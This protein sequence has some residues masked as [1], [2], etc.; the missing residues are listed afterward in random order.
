MTWTTACPDWEQR[1]IEGRS[2]VPCEPLFPGEAERA[3][4]VFR[5]L[6]IVDVPGQPTFGEACGQ[7]VFDFVSA[8]FGSYDAETGQRLVREFLLAVS[9]KNSKALALDTPI[10][11][12]SGWTTMG[13]L[14]P[15]DEVFGVDGR[16]CR[17]LAT[18]E[19][20]TDHRC[21]QLEFSNGESVVADAGHLWLT[22]ALAD[23]PGVGRGNSEGS[24]DNRRK[25]V[26]TTQEIVDTL[27][28]PGDG[29]RNH[30]IL[31][32]SA[33]QCDPAVL[34][35]EP[36]TLGAW[37]GDGHSKCARITC[38]RDDTEILDGIRA[39]GWPIRF[40][41]NNGSAADTYSI[42]DGDRSQ[43]ARRV[44]LAARLR[45]AGVL[46]SKHIP[47]VYFRASF[48]QRLALLQGL[49]DTDGTVNKNGRV[50]SFSGINRRLVE[51]VQELLS[52]FGVKSSLT[53][54]DARLDGRTVGTVHVVQFMAFRDELPVFRLR[55][56]LDRMRASSGTA[57]RSRTVQIV[58]AREVPSVPVKCISVDAPDRQFLF[59]RTMLPT[60]NSTLAAAIMVTA[61]VLNWRQSGELLI[62]A[63]T[64]EAA[65]N[66]FKPAA[67]MVRADPELNA[68]MHI[69]DH[70]KTITHRG[71]KAT[72][73]VVAADTS[74]V[75]G[76]K[77]GFVLIDELWE[78]GTK[79]NAEAMLQEATG[80]LVSRPE[81][82]VIAITTQSDRPPAGVFKARLNYFRKVRD[83][84]IADP[85][86]LAV[87][88]EFPRR[89]I[90]DG[91]Y[92][93]PANFYITNPNIGR[94]VSREWIEDQLRKV[95][96]AGGDAYHT[97]LAKHL[98]V[99][100]GQ[101]IGA[102]SWAGAQFWQA[103]TEKDLD[104]DRLLA[105]SEVV[106][107]GIDGGGLDDLLSLSVLGRDAHNPRIWRHWGH[108][109][110]AEVVLERRKSEAS[111][112]RDFE[113]AGE[114]TI[115]DRPGRDIDE[116]VAVCERVDETG[117][118]AFVGLDPAGVGAIVDALA[119]K[120]IGGE[121]DPAKSR[122]VGVSQGY[123]LQGAVK[124]AERKLA[125]GTLTHC[126][127]AIMA[128]AVGNAKVEQKGNALMVTKQAAGSKIDPVMSLFDSVALMTKNPVAPGKQVSPWEDETY[129]LAVI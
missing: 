20:F 82:F 86:S 64:I 63:P 69:Q 39:E 6:R 2:L 37:L 115:V 19:V 93:D 97:F 42:T 51:G 96:E 48:D 89:M 83:G 128:W 23:R 90:D 33:I 53:T 87:I 57:S 127:Q 99:E 101:S 105:R 124:T 62:L 100:I 121:G 26:R 28:R 59:G 58:G 106:V 108:S 68:L 74:T 31:M 103:Q 91:A 36:Y 47:D 120:G 56:K 70:I 12:P 25:R 107:V 78:F 112:L 119:E 126:G 14:K 80:G 79:P 92:L 60:H 27:L 125:E 98:N 110:A 9:K 50:L 4:A 22:K 40:A 34:P 72:L 16:P 85:K 65:Q 75:V 44:C 94:S 43:S 41:H 52:T 66:S 73:K 95:R 24:K 88:Y 30:S 113:K 54:R 11:T 29:A 49:M 46:G 109:W 71:T 45:N 18:S 38:H 5:S 116:L 114:L 61:L 123:Q 129:S 104:L 10:P 17:V 84:V 111:R 8:V 32:P 21:Y 13:E 81:G 118:L 7:W 102:D 67:D 1:L 77:A 122:V 55:R 3:L 117:L 35:I 15:G 76:K